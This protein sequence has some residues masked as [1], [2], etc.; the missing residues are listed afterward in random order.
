MKIS[1]DSS[2]TC[3]PI[4]AQFPFSKNLEGNFAKHT[5]RDRRIESGHRRIIPL[6]LG[7]VGENGRGD[8]YL[9]ACSSIGYHFCIALL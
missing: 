7:R 2:S 8:C 1:V 9:A 6:A 4:Q 3:A 5:S